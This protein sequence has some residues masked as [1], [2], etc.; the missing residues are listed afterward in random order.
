MHSGDSEGMNG[1]T[2][3]LDAI[4]VIENQRIVPWSLD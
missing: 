2:T 1:V 3:A 4:Q